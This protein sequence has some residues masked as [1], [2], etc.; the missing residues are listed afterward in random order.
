MEL[1]TNNSFANHIYNDLT[2]K[3]LLT[4]YFFTN[5]IYLIYGIFDAV[6]SRN[7]DVGK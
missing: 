6:L 2:K 4:N 1:P 7:Y 3:M 5:Q